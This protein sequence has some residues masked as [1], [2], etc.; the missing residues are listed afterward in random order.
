MGH[1]PGAAQVDWFSTLQHPLPVPPSASPT[2][3]RSCFTVINQT[4]SP[5]TR[6]GFSSTTAMK[7]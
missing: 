6:C 4:G 7:M 2:R 5:A 3:Q 1:I